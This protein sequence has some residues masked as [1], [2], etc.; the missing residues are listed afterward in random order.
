MATI[1]AAHKNAATTQ[2]RA[3][4]RG[5]YDGLFAGLKIA[6]TATVV[7]GLLALPTFLIQRADWAKRPEWYKNMFAGAN[8]TLGL[9]LAMGASAGIVLGIAAG[10]AVQNTQPHASLAERAMWGAAITAPG[11]AF[12]G[13]LA[14]ITPWEQRA[15]SVPMATLQSAGLTLGGAAIA[16]V[17]GGLAGIIPA[18]LSND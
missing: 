13:L 14:G 18:P 4:L 6:G 5:R 9:G 1:T 11:G 7:G 3:Q 2:H 17:I 12:I 8:V 15:V 10:S 16:G